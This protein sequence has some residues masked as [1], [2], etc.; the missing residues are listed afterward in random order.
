MT[1]FYEGSLTLYAFVKATRIRTAESA[2]LSIAY[3]KSL[4]TKQWPHSEGQ[5]GQSHS[6]ISQKTE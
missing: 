6:G 5:A 2:Q 1:F 3:I 4:I